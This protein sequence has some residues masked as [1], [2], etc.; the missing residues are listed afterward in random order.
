MTLFWALKLTEVSKVKA[1]Q[2]SGGLSESF[3]SSG[4]FVQLAESSGGKL[5]FPLTFFFFFFSAQYAPF[6]MSKQYIFF[7]NG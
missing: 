4:G 2:S 7:F 1:N 3:E 5:R 6:N